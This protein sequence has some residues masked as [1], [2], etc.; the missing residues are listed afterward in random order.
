MNIFVYGTLRHGLNNH[1]Y[2][3]DCSKY[4]G[5][6]M[7]QGFDLLNIANR[8]PSMIPSSKHRFVIG[9]IYECPESILETLDFVEGVAMGLYKRAKLEI[10]NESKEQIICMTYVNANRTYTAKNFPVVQHGDWIID[11]IARRTRKHP[12]QVIS[13][14]LSREGLNKL[15]EHAILFKLKD[16]IQKQVDLDKIRTEEELQ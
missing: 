9:E 3:E 1:Q 16:R 11:Y 15:G 10:T 7:V 2:I 5:L 12:L 4:K 14:I 6:G 13:S 8:Y